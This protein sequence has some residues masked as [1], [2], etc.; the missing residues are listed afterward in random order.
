MS[1]VIRVNVEQ[2]NEYSRQL[3]G[4]WDKMDEVLDQLDKA[5]A[6][7]NENWEGDSLDA[8]NV[9]YKDSVAKFNSVMEYIQLF[10][11]TVEKTRDNFMEM[12]A[13]VRDAIKGAF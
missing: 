10:K 3:Q 1:E 8:Y 6:V 13:A 7:L 2:M 12:D 5:T 4:I 9:Q 11:G